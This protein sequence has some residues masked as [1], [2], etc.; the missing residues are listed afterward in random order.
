M[1]WSDSGAALYDYL[2]YM[3]LQ[4]TK[5]GLRMANDCNAGMAPIDLDEVTCASISSG[6]GV[7]NSANRTY[8]RCRR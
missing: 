2:D 1:R 7:R 5:I 6:R 8:L 3:M 4:R